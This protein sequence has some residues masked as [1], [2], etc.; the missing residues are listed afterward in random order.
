MNVKNELDKSV[1]FINDYVGE[2]ERT[3]IPVSRR[4]DSNV[5][6]RVCVK[7]L[8]RTCKAIFNL[9]RRGRG[10]IS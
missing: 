1:Q 10:E 9:T 6:V 4:I 7:T 8:G 3:M 5:V 2:N